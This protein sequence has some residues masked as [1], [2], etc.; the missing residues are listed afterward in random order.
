MSR[1]LILAAIAVGTAWFYEYALVLAFA[2]LPIY[3]LPPGFLRAAEGVGGHRLL[4]ATI[5]GLDVLITVA[6]SIPFAILISALYSHRWLLV[7]A[8]VAL[9]ATL[10]GIAGAPTVWRALPNHA[11]Y[12]TDLALASIR[13]LL[14]LPLLTFYFRSAASNTRRNARA[15]SSIPGVGEGR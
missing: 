3:V 15:A 6:V 9:W 14:V 2:H 8:I 7:A 10:P 11:G 13:L 5:L 4:R 1:I 12:V